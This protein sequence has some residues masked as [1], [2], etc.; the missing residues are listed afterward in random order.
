M[1]PRYLPASGPLGLISLQNCQIPEATIPLHYSSGV[2]VHP[3]F[4]LCIFL[5]IYKYIFKRKERK[6]K[7][8]SDPRMRLRYHWKIMF[9]KHCLGAPSLLCSCLIS[10]LSVKKFSHQKKKIFIYLKSNDTCK[11]IKWILGEKI[12]FLTFLS[13]MRHK[14]LLEYESTERLLY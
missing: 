7:N 6:K 8:R 13:K 3:C 9:W 2:T 10:T 14:V 4:I 11:K 1:R 12:S 5:F